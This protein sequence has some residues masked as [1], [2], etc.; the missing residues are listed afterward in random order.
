MERSLLKMRLG[1]A[2]GLLLAGCAEVGPPDYRQDL[3]LVCAEIPERYFYFEEKADYWDEACAQAQAELTVEA[4]PFEV[5]TALEKVVDA[6]YDPHVSFN[7]NSGSSPRLLP[8]GADVWFEKEGES[9]VLTGL[10]TGSGAA[11][12]GLEIGDRF[13]SFNDLGADALSMTRIQAGLTHLPEARRVWALNAAI[14]GYRG[15]PRNIKIERAGAAFSFVLGDPE[16]AGSPEAL[17]YKMLEGGIGH[18]RFN[19]SLGNNVTVESFYDAMTTLGDV[20]GLIL[21]LRNTPGG[22]NTDVAEPILGYFIDQEQS[23]Q[24]VLPK[25]KDSYLRKVS[26]SKVGHYDGPMIVLSG[27]WTGSMGEGMTVGLDAMARATVMGDRMAGLAGGTEGLRLPEMDISLFIPTYGLNHL[28]GTKRHEWAPD[29]VRTADF[30]DGEDLLLK[31]AHA[32]LAQ[33]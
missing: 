7:S 26:P 16:P 24:M 6:L 15:A 32:R 29:I 10:R 23:Y 18:I 3:A 11:R 21:D 28:D 33:P 25:G 2:F 22:G 19:N 20:K 8:S 30:G 17:T 31:A 9:Y 13:V 5:L 12:S 4:T 27:R 14:A 1:S